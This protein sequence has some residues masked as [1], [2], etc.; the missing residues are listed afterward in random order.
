[1]AYDEDLAGRIQDLLAG[2]KHI[3]QKKMFGGLGFLLRGNILVGVWKNSL[4]ARL[5][6][7]D[8]EDALQEPHV[9]VFDITGKAMKGWVMVDPQAL[10]ETGSLESWINRAWKFVRTLPAK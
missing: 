2:Q 5:G 6:P 10:A 3:V 1:M 4:I 9:R 8:A 7:D